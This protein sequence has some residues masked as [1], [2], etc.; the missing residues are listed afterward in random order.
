MNKA[1]RLLLGIAL[2]LGSTALAAPVSRYSVIQFFEDVIQQ[3]LPDE[4]VH[5]K[6]VTIKPEEVQHLLQGPWRVLYACSGR[7]LESPSAPGNKIIFYGESTFSIFFLPTK[8]QLESGDWRS[9][10][11]PKTYPYELKPEQSIPGHVAVL[12]G[13]LGLAQYRLAEVEESG[14]V[15]LIDSS[16]ERAVERGRVCREGERYEIIQ[17]R[18]PISL[19]IP[20]NAKPPETLNR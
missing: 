12:E 19:R 13:H 3:K 2:G 1:T 15:V 4:R 6:Q 11:T 8:A 7:P 20:Q 14:E 10:E 16:E 18:E 5:F 17:A 9:N